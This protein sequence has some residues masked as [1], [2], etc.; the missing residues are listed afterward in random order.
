MQQVTRSRRRDGNQVTRGG[1]VLLGTLALLLSFAGSASATFQEVD[2]F[3]VEV[4]TLD[5]TIDGDDLWQVGGGTFIEDRISQYT[6]GGTLRATWKIAGPDDPDFPGN[7]FAITTDSSGNVIAA[8]QCGQSAAAC[9]F[10]FSPEGA[11]IRKFGPGADNGGHLWLPRGVAVDSEGNIY[12]ADA[13]EGVVVKYDSDGTFLKKWGESV[14][15]WSPNGIAI[16]ADDNVYVAESTWGGDNCAEGGDC[17]YSVYKYDTDGNLLKT[18]GDG[19]GTDSGL[20]DYVAVDRDGNV[21][22]SGGFGSFVIQVFGPGG[23]EKAAINP[24]EGA[25]CYSYSPSGLDFASNGDLYVGLFETDLILKFRDLPDSESA[26][27]LPAPAPAARPARPTLNASVK[28]KTAK[29]RAV[30]RFFSSQ[31]GAHFQCKLTGRR[32]PK[33]LRRWSSCTSPKRYARLKPGKKVFWVRA[34]GSGKVGEAARRAWRIVK[35]RLHQVLTIPTTARTAIF[36]AVCPLA[37]R[38]RARVRIAAGKKTLARGRYAVPPHKSRKVRIGLTKTGRKILS[39]KRR[40]RAK[41][42]IID[43]RTHKRETVAVVM[44]RR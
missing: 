28:G 31:P 5:L 22:T 11:L 12:V 42:K 16:D 44:K 17:Y 24:E 20:K 3:G 1:A 21:Y 33:K 15:F 32:V 27:P 13:N 4:P 43:T 8:D 2:R 36:R 25:C 18:F 41:L 6:L 34:V 9:V 30:F 10:V 26:T 23:G 35:H 14:A 39:R 7:P 19:E 29:R 38:C 40:V 37:K